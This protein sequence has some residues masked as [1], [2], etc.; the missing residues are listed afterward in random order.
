M[1]EQLLAACVALVRDLEERLE[2]VPF[3]AMRATEAH[4]VPDS[5]A[6]RTVIGILNSDGHSYLLRPLGP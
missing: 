2:E 4:A 5:I 6:D 1:M 3:G